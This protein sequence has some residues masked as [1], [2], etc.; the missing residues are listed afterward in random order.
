MTELEKLADRV[1]QHVETLANTGMNV[2]LMDWDRISNDLLAASRALRS[3][4]LV[5]GGWRSDMEN[6]PRDGT[7]VELWRGES[8]LGVWSRSVYARWDVEIEAWVWPDDTY[9]CVSEHGREEA[10]RLLEK[11]DLYEDAENW[12]HWRPITPPTDTPT[13]SDRVAELEGEVARLRGAI[14][15]IRLMV[16][17][18]AFPSDMSLTRTDSARDKVKRIKHFIDST[19]LGG[20]S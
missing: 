8:K 9:D 6:A 18:I 16:H 19:A 4:S 20:E 3:G 17:D 14:S 5:P 7:W 13:Q 10:E 11:G 2:S 12:T 1:D 15:D